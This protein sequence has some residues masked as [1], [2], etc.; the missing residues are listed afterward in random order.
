MCPS[1]ELFVRKNFPQRLGVTIVG[2]GILLSCV[3]WSYYEI[4]WTF[5]ILV[6]TALIDVALYALVGDVVECYGCHARYSNLPNPRAFEAFDLEV[7]ERHRQKNARL[8]E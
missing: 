2:I 1:T 4:Y 8:A 7:H 6:A 5:G 3:A